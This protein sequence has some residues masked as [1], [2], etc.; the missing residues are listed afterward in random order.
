MPS[1]VKHEVYPGEELG[2]EVEQL[3]EERNQSVSGVYKEGIRRL[4]QREELNNE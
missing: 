4:L 2:Q 3:A 1:K